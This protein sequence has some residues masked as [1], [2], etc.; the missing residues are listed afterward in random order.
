[1]K[2]ENIL[3][4][5]LFDEREERITARIALFFLFLTQMGLAGIIFYRRYALHQTNSQ[6]ADLNILLAASLFGFIAI[7]L[8]F[9]AGLPVPSLKTTLMIYAG[10]VFLLGVILTLWYGFPAPG[11]WKTTILPVMLGPAILLAA[12]H[13][14]AV[15]GRKRMEKELKE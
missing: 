6:I 15:L 14:F 7:R 9:G 2:K 1:M 10:F 11:E 13:L 4:S 12:Y 3:K 8:I 5:F